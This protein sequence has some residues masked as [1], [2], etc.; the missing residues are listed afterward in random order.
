MAINRIG[1]FEFIELGAPPPLV[2]AQIAGH[3]RAGVDGKMLQLLGAWAEPFEIES[4]AGA[5]TYAHA[6]TL[7]AAYQGLRGAGPVQMV[8]SDFALAA[9]RHVF[10]V[11]DVRA[12]DIQN[13][14]LGVGPGGLYFAEL[15]AVW[16]LQPMRF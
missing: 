6:W 1:L 8:W 12:T 16:R 9:A 7:Y 3:Q 10:H 14:V 15:R 13:L 2:G 4:L 11:L 5:F